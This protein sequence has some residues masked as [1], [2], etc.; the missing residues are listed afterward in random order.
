MVLVTLQGTGTLGLLLLSFQCLFPLIRI[1]LL[2]FGFRFLSSLW[3]LLYWL[4]FIRPTCR[5][6]WV[7]RPL[8]IR[9]D[10]SERNGNSFTWVE[11]HHRFGARNHN[12]NLHLPHIE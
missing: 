6:S 8:R 9:P 10:Q 5:A 12:E 3:G 1:I 2:L 4:P 11:S 7:S